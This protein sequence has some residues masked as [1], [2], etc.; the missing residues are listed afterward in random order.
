MVNFL[1]SN[2]I[3]NFFNRMTYNIAQ[4]MNI[5]FIAA[6]IFFISVNNCAAQKSTDSLLQ[7]IKSLDAYHQ[8]VKNDSNEQMIN[9]QKLIPN[10]VL[11]L[12]YATTNNFMHQVMYP[13]K[14]T[15]TFLRLPA[16][17]ALMQVQK[18]LNKNGF[19]LKIFDAYRP[20]SVT[21]KFW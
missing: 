19:G 5:L 11:D 8:T 20:Y 2:I 12:R 14:P 21:E 17:K 6:T 4:R 9:V 16:A 10:I 18:E 1:L 13:E 3:Q 15:Y 7:V